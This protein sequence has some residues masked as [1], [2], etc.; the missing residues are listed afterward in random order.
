MS[1]GMGFGCGQPIERDATSGMACRGLF[2]ANRLLSGAQGIGM[3]VERDGGSLRAC[4]LAGCGLRF[5]QHVAEGCGFSSTIDV[6]EETISHPASLRADKLDTP[7]Y[8]RPHN[9]MLF[10]EPNMEAA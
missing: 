5:D 1:R 10:R 2:D 3:Q 9:D 8:K 4:T 7:P 6:A